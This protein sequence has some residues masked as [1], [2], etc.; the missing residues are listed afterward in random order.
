MEWFSFVIERCNFDLLIKETYWGLSV[1][2]GRL[3][4]IEPYYRRFCKRFLKDSVPWARDNIV[5][6]LIVL[7]VPPLAALLH[8]PRFNVD[9]VLIRNTLLLYA[10]VLAFYLVVK[11]AFTA[12]NLDNDR[13]LGEQ[14]LEAAI[15]ERDRTIQEHEDEIKVLK[16]K[17]KRTPAE[18]HDYD[19]IKKVLTMFRE[20]KIALSH[21]RG[22]RKLSFGNFGSS[23][24]PN[25]PVSLTSDR[26]LLVYRHCASEGILHCDRNLGNSM[27]TFTIPDHMSKVLDEALFSDEGN[28]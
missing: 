17:P 24:V 23:H 25:L 13:S 2:M 6:G 12:K 19:K 9:W 18:Q 10:V 3:E 1:E 8:N 21:I 14:V 4:K 7:I 20:S 5:W 27:E 16:Q 15:F 22:Q 11:M 26:A 28:P